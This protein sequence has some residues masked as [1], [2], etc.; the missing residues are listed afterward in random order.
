[1]SYDVEERAAKVRLQISAELSDAIYGGLTV[2]SNSPSV[3]NSLVPRTGRAAA[4]A[5][6]NLAL[7]SPGDA[8][9]VRNL[10]NEIEVERRIVARLKEAVTVGDE[11]WRELERQE[12]A[13]LQ[14]LQD[15]VG[16][17][18]EAVEV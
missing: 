8:E 6:D 12:K 14:D 1:M 5:L 3:L 7:V 10:Q 4:V 17:I 9:A 2:K 18:Y 11:D 13:D 16:M 15:G